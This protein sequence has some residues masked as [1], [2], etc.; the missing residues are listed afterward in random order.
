LRDE[1]KDDEEAF[2]ELDK[3]IQRIRNKKLRKETKKIE[4]ESLET[5]YNLLIISL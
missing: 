4:D 5:K 3:Q 1:R 2:Q